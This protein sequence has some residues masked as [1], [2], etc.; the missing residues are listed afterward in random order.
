M[1]KWI[2]ISDNETTAIGTIGY[3]VGT[4]SAGRETF[5]LRERPLRT[6]QSNEPR[7]YGWCGET[8]NKSRAA[9]G[10]WKIVRVNK[11]GDRAQIVMLHAAELT[12]WLEADG[13]PGLICSAH[14]A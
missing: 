13:H 4:T 9:Y 10:V 3:L 8:N 5:S 14:A 7:L 6:N 1:S 12:A 11:A 2:D